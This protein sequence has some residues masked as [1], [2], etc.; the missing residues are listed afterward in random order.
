VNSVLSLRGGE[1]FSVLSS[2]DNSGTGEGY[3]RATQVL[4]DPF[5]GVSHSFTDK[6][7]T[8]VNPAAFADGPTGTF[9]GAS[10]RNQ[11]YGQGFEDVDLSVF[12]TGSIGEWVKIQFRAELFNLFNR[13]N[14]APPS[15]TVGDG[16]GVISDTI[17]D[18]NGAP[19]IGPGEPFNTQFGLKVI[20]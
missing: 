10:R 4:H 11:L 8:W 1:P 16:F 19:G 14:L 18:Y 13:K 17:G 20:F 12:K 7:V 15:N 6:Q 5:A 3:Q 2:T 9:S